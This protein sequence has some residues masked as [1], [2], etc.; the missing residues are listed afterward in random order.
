MNKRLLEV[1][2]SV[3]AI[4]LFL[5]ALWV[6][7]R[8]LG[9][10][11]LADIIA[12]FR[13]I[14]F[15]HVLMALM[16]SLLS[17]LALSG[18]DMLALRHIKHPLEYPK[19]AMTS[20]I[21]Y[22]IAHN[23]GFSVFTGG[24]LRYRIYGAWGLSALEITTLMGFGVATFWLGYLT[25]A[26][27]VLTTAP[28]MIPE[29]IR[30][31]FVSTIPLGLFFVGLLLAY[32]V[33]ITLFR[34][35]IKVKGWQF[36]IPTL[37]TTFAQMALGTFDW[38][39]AAGAIY[40]VLPDSAQVSYF[41]VLGI[42]LLSQIAGLISNIPGGL[43]VFETVFILL[44]GPVATP[45]ELVGSLLAY[46]IVYY[47][48]PLFVAASSLAAFEI[49]RK[50]EGLM[51][52]AANVGR[53][54][55]MIAPQLFSFL[56][57]ISGV[58]LLFSSATPAESERMEL[59]RDFLP[60]P[61][62]ELSHFIG[63]IAGLGLL[64][65]ARGLQR[66]VDAAYVL[67]LFL[68]GV[69]VVV[70]LLKGFDYEEAL[71]LSL[72]LLLLLPSRSYF[73]R[74]S[75]LL[76]RSLSPAWIGAIVVVLACSF[77]LTMFSFKHVEYGSKLWWQFEFFGDAPRSLRAGAGVVSAAL[78][79]AIWRLLRPAPPEPTLP[80]LE[81]LDNTM[82]I[83]KSCSSSVSH[84]ALIGDKELLF[85]RNGRAF[86]MYGISGRTWAAMG[87]PVGSREEWK[88]L[89]WQFHE[90]SDRHGGWTAFY[91]V[92]AENLPL[93]LEMGLSL[94]KLGEEAIVP[95]SGFSLEGHANKPFRH[96]HRKPESEG[97]SFQIVPPEEV[98][99]LL[100]RLREISDSWLEYKNTR[101]K[102]FSLGYFYEPY[103]TRMPMALVWKDRT[104]HRVCQYLGHG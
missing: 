87:D 32:L 8:E 10:H 68:L 37:P 67:S 41:H 75:S 62:I 30:L 24:S 89:L 74:K 9:H 80:S 27:I 100:P 6:L 11:R 54:I 76:G 103:L 57:F 77:W 1:I 13:S 48:V 104:D 65:L 15:P 44:I 63:S 90:M 82:P 14:P 4:G 2:G 60:L 52:L 47:L 40:I 50:R 81:V 94:L 28:V 69:G 86:I 72:M 98:K 95:L 96:W 20:F 23:L 45:A 66:R 36:D 64:L 92:D 16:F 3:I 42:F 79:L 70:S 61:V 7:H 101:E 59:L 19:V 21:T 56:V 34:S 25:T 91:Q 53:W 26:A 38:L 5:A 102:R 17:Y 39:M 18:Y 93:Y 97:C 35:P 43:G 46:R 22:A 84:L 58:V 88:E 71:I 78:L 99:A 51:K 83:V 33:K 12:Q 55:S 29:Q 31:P 85:S 73:Y 49:S